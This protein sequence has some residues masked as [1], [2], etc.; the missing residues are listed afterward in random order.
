MTYHRDIFLSVERAI[1]T[2]VRAR[3]SVRS[4]SF[5]LFARDATEG[6]KRAELK[7][8]R[9]RPGVF[10]PLPASGCTC[11]AASGS[12][13]SGIIDVPGE[14]SR[15]RFAGPYFSRLGSSNA[16]TVTRACVHTRATSVDCASTRA[17]KKR[18][19]G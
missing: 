16:R 15:N 11:V 19:A 14:S 9:K 6:K 1:H 4:V 10:T 5:S 8:G 12:R 2:R 3:G 17:L 18:K 7:A 13:R